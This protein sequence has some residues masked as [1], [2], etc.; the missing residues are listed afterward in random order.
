MQSALRS[1]L[2][3]G[4]QLRYFSNKVHSHASTTVFGA[5]KLALSTVLGATGMF[6]LQ[7]RLFSTEVFASELMECIEVGESASLADGQMREIQVGEDKDRDIV[8]IARVDGQ[9]FAV[10]AKCS[11][12]GVKLGFGVLF[13]D[14]VYCPAHMASFDV[15][16]G[17]PDGGPVYNA[18]KTFETYE[19]D[20][21]M[22]IK[23]PRKIEEHH[24]QLPTSTI[25]PNNTDKYV[26][27]GGGP[28][29]LSAAETLRQSGFTGKIVMITNE[30]TLPYDRTVLT[31][32]ALKVQASGVVIRDE[33]YFKKNG[34]EFMLNTGVKNLNNEAKQLELSNGETLSYDKLLLATGMS[35]KLPDVAGNDMNNVFTIRNIDDCAKLQKSAGNVKN[36]VVIGGS[37]I[38]T[39]IAANIKDELKDQVNIVVCTRGELFQNTL[40]PVV[41]AAARKLHETNGVQFL[42]GKTLSSITGQD[43]NASGVEFTDGTSLKADMVILGTGCKPNTQFLGNSTI[44]KS[45]GD[46]VNCDVFMR[47]NDKNVY[48]SG[49]VA[50]YPYFYTAERLNCSHYS[51]A[52][53]QGVY[54]AWN[55]LGKNVPYDMVPMFWTK[56]WMKN[57]YYTGS[58]KNYDNVSFFC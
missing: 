49:D 54:S 55:M 18:L 57:I 21:K 19:K 32:N 43:N 31:K 53:S 27:V 51:D 24:V 20:G 42:T 23:A 37:F 8:L 15:R 46:F 12:Y 9:L 16:T 56:S 25:D 5:N 17:A 28:S 2:R 1:A 36:I 30:S 35:A 13:G 3:N 22:F 50:S 52:I 41:G 7:S 10:S 4:K 38:G 14:R 40:G 58:S 39:E 33:E 47:T 6:Y 29:G 48:A 11:H 45:E 34:I 44:T 26:I